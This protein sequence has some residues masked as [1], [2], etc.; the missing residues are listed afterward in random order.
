MNYL[1]IA[2]KLGLDKDVKPSNE[3]IN[4]SAFIKINPNKVIIKAR[5][6]LFITL[7]ISMIVITLLTNNLLIITLS[8]I[9]AL[10]TYYYITEKPKIKAREER[11]NGLGHAPEIITTIGTSLELNPNLERAIRLAG[12]NCGGRISKDL[13]TA[14]KNSIING[15]SLKESFDKIIIDWGNHSDGFKHGMNLIKT[16]LM[17]LNDADR[18]RT[19]ERGMD[20]FF[21]GLINELRRFLGQIKTHTLILFSFGTIIPLILISLLPMVN[22]LNIESNPILLIILLGANLLLIN[23][24]TNHALKNKPAGFSELDVKN[25]L[26]QGMMRL[27]FN[28]QGF[29]VPAKAYTI[30]IFL[31]IASPTIIYY[32]SMIAGNLF[33]MPAEYASMPLILGL[34][35]SLSLYFHGTSHPSIKARNKAL[36]NESELLEVVYSIGTKLQE[37]RSFEDSLRQVVNE[38]KGLLINHLSRAYRNISDLRTPVEESI[39]TELTKTGS[40]RVISVF[41]LLFNALKQGVDKS[42]QCVFRVYE[43]FN[44][45]IQ[46]EEEHKSMLEQVLSMMK[47]TAVFFAPLISAFIIIMQLII[48]VNVTGLGVAFFNFQ[49]LINADL[50]TLLLGIY[51]IGLV[52]VLTRYHTLLKNGPDQV[53]LR[54]ELSIN[55]LFATTIYLGTLLLSKLL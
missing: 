49:G 35:L 51:T 18:E 42:S 33:L 29:D 8:V 43:H 46:A 3:L 27:G 19:I 9:P 44:R 12:D 11:L 48:E 21:N 37:K 16:S 26:K 30:I 1:I 5:L 55:I 2:K 36:K 32:T 22:L 38:N 41:K 34:G 50:M 24:Y 25:N 54:H 28:G 52:I 15:Q 39:I 47:I 7:I 20:S 45:M 31:L 53:L 4:A 40:K 6:W 14:Y 10:I 13:S 17:E 23:E